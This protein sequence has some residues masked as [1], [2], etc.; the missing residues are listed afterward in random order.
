MQD[1][2]R[3]AGN[4]AASAVQTVSGGELLMPMFHCLEPDGRL[5]MVVL[6]A[7]T[8]E[9]AM[10]AGQRMYQENTQQAIGAV[11]IVDGFVTHKEV[12]KVDALILNVVSYAEPR[13]EMQLAVPYRHAHSHEGFAVFKPKLLGVTGIAQDELQPLIDAFYQGRDENAEGRVIWKEHQQDHITG[14]T[15]FAGFSGEDWKHLR[16]AP[17]AIFCMVASADGEIDAKE[18]AAFGK[19]FKESGKYPS[20]LMQR[21]MTELSPDTPSGRAVLMDF[22][23]RFS[24]P[25]FNRLQY[26]VD[27]N[28]LLGQQASDTDAAA[29]KAD[30]L[31]LGKAVAESSGGGFLGFGSKVSKEEKNVLVVIEK[32]LNSPLQL[33]QMMADLVAPDR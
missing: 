2:Y 8:G 15:G 10:Q 28:R 9:E 18:A 16:E 31:A 21:V 13:R 3:M 27:V 4:A 26:L 14:M 1:I 17:V 24:D 5:K 33:A 22:L 20:V 11:W 29:F 32:L 7:D 30:L 6:M 19:L 23:Q 12:G 25:A